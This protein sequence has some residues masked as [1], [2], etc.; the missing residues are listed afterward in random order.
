VIPVHFIF[1]VEVVQTI[2]TVADGFHWFVFGYGDMQ[3]LNE[4]FLSNFD[5]PIMSAVIAL[6]V[7][8]V[9][10]WRVWHLSGLK[11]IS[12]LIVL[13]RKFLF[14]ATRLIT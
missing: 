14:V 12:G 3:K 5:T 9:Y 4:F 1:F 6:V 11:F 13:V 8:S 2:F 7:Q 10:A